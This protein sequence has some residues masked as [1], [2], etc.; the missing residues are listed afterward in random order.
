MTCRVRASLLVLLALAPLLVS[1]KSTQKEGTAQRARGSLKRSAGRPGVAILFEQIKDGELLA[2]SFTCEVPEADAPARLLGVRVKTPAN[3]TVALR[4][5][6]ETTFGLTGELASM[7]A[8]FPGGAYLVLLDTGAGTEELHRKLA[9]EVAPYPVI[10]EPTHRQ[11]GVSTTP[12]IRL[13]R[14]TPTQSFHV[15][16]EQEDMATDELQN[17]SARVVTIG[18]KSD[19]YQL[20]AAQRLKP[21]TRYH[22]EVEAHG[23]GNRVSRAAL[24]F[25]TGP[26]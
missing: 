21:M 14:G 2:G 17:S 19:S 15:Q 1:C 20:T 3:E 8:R 25:T 16:V 22:L 6:D 18:P 10:L 9:G 11:S 26:K 24:H 7:A 23:Q 4:R 12:L 13:E 5:E